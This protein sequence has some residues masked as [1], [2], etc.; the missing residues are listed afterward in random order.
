MVNNV[1]E[2]K[3]QP[4]L[5]VI[6]VNWNTLRITADCIQ[7][8]IDIKE[9]SPIEIIVIDNASTDG[10]AEHFKEKFS[11]IK[12]IENKSNV[13]FAEGCNQGLEIAQGKYLLLLNPDTIAN[14]PALKGMIEFLKTHPI[15]GAVGC[16]L[17][18]TDGTFQRAYGKFIT[19]F[20]F[21]ISQSLVAVLLRRF[22]SRIRNFLPV[23]KKRKPFSVD[24][25]MGACIMMPQSIYRKIGGFDPEYFMYCEDA[26]WCFRVKK[27][28]YWIYHV[29]QFS[30]Y[31][32]HQQSSRLRKKF[33]FVRI[34]LSFRKFVL[35]HY[36][37]AMYNRFRLVVLLEMLIRLPVYAFFWLITPKARSWQAERLASTFEVIKIYLKGDKDRD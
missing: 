23:L 22:I 25:L 21:L 6:I 34:F 7:S 15:V 12:L 31:H 35:K 24:W 30:I 16:R 19:P 17:L 4:E 33:T 36:G 5:S 10:S 13:G 3:P 1:T 2:T 37:A 32:Y 8:L 20:N 9:V 18:Y 27:E 11:S 28:G 14:E 26:D 29:P